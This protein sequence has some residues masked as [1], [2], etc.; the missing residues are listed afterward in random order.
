MKRL[1]I[2]IDEER[3]NGC[4]QCILDCAEGALAIVDGKAKLIKDSYCDGLGACLNCPEGALQLIEREADDFDEEEALTAKAER[5][6]HSGTSAAGH[7]SHAQSMAHA[8]PKPGGCPGSMARALKPLAPGAVASNP[9][10]TVELPSWPIQL[11]L[12][13]PTAPFLKG[14]HILLAAHCAG[15]ALP[16][17]HKDWIAGRIPIIACPKLENNEALLEKLTA[18]IKSGQIAKLTVLR[19]SVP[20]CGGLERLVLQ[21][22][23]D[24]QSDLQMECHVV[25]V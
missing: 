16:N 9:Q 4:G 5:E 25:T 12:V 8:M 7:H 2:Q 24:A 6:G 15:F 17:L 14:A 20:C 21:A 18:I 1:I 22:L 23:K 11:R 3:C 13:P 19:M 10:L